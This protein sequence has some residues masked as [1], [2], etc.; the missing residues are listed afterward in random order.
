[1][2]VLTANFGQFWHGV[3]TKRLEGRLKAQVTLSFDRT[4]WNVCYGSGKLYERLGMYLVN[5]FVSVDLFIVA[6]QS[7]IQPLT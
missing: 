2:R 3:L 4:F 1:M 6:R 7:G 5:D